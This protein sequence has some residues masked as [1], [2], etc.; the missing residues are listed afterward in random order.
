MVEKLERTIAKVKFEWLS[1]VFVRYP[2]I[3][4]LI[5]G[6][7]PVQWRLAET[8]AGDVSGW[9][10]ASGDRNSGLLPSQYRSHILTYTNRP[11]LDDQARNMGGQPAAAFRGPGE[12]VLVTTLSFGDQEVKEPET[13]NN[14]ELNPEAAADF[15]WFQKDLGEEVDHLA[16]LDNG[17]KVV[18]GIGRGAVATTLGVYTPGDRV[19][20]SAEGAVNN[21]V[22][23]PSTSMEVR[24]IHPDLIFV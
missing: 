7:N 9:Q 11:R 4:K 24:E 19:F 17:L 15:S 5:V 13:A 16:D 18:F 1:G 23:T 20:A 10:L 3:G 14:L 6:D 12:T 22:I 2:R 21:F 8:R